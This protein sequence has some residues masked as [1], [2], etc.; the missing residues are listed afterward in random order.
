MKLY[1]LFISH[2]WAYGS[3]YDNLVALLNADPRF[4]YRNY[5]VPKDDPIHRA[6]TD[7]ELADAIQNQMRFCDAI[8]ILGGK[9]S[10]YSKWIQKEISIAKAFTNPKP[11]IGIRPWGAL[12]VSQIVQDHA[13]ELVAWNT[14]SIVTAIR[15][16]S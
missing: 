16:H 6:G 15:N 1:N 3:D 4:N 13:D 10:T 7:R 9:Y 14:S 11:I 12:Q 5:S 2:S 8:I